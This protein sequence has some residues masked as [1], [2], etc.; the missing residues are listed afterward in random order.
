MSLEGNIDVIGIEKTLTADENNKIFECQGMDRIV[1]HSIKVKVGKTY[2]SYN[3]N[4]AKGRVP[5]VPIDVGDAF[6]MGTGSMIPLQGKIINGYS[7]AAAEISGFVIVRRMNKK[8]N[9][10]FDLGNK[11]AAYTE[12]VRNFLRFIKNQAEVPPDKNP[13]TGGLTAE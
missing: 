8:G 10:M 5:D 2:F 9:E 3:P 6:T 4:G 1:G 7:T 13:D 12:E 11:I